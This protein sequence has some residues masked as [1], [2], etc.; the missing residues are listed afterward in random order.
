M[1]ALERAARSSELLENTIFKEA[2]ASIRADLIGK[3]ETVGFDD[4]DKQHELTLMLQ[5]LKQVKTRLERW[6]DDGKME[7]KAI[8]QKNWIEKARQRFRA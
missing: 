1:N 7:A 6:V 3:L 8:E 2:M 4:I 5:L